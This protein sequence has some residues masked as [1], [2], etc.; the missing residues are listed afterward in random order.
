MIPLSSIFLESVAAFCGKTTRM[1]R[2]VLATLTRITD[3]RRG[4]RG[5]FELCSSFIEAWPLCITSILCGGG[6]LLRGQAIKT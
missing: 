5:D 2:G 3:T 4:K 1:G 6:T